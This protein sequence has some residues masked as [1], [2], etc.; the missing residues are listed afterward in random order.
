MGYSTMIYAVDLGK[1]KTAVGSRDTRLVKRLLPGGKKKKKRGMR[2]TREGPWVYLKS[3]G[4]I[5]VNGQIVPYKK[6]I[7]ELRQRKWK[8]KNLYYGEANR[9]QSGP[10]RETQS[11]YE[12]IMDAMPDTQFESYESFKM[13]P[14]GEEVDEISIEEAAAEL[15]EGNV[16]QP[17][18][19][20]QYGYGLE[21]LCKEIGTFL[22][23]IE[24]SGM[25]QAL[26]L[27]TPLSKKRSPIPLKKPPGEFPLI[28]YLTA[29][30]VEREVKRL[31]GMDLSF[32]KDEW[33][34]QD[35]K[36]FLVALRKAAK[37]RLGVVAF[38]H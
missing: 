36:E 20:H 33:I 21:C 18:M 17:E 29:A 8:G 14:G 25:L 2:D 6:V 35:R 28:G 38:Y 15:V 27:N 32:P 26:K 12:A 22:A 10:W 4:E 11:L 23:G 13:S 34:E 7:T 3:N 31:E 9:I 37:K 24:G 5:L 30:E 1:L 19:G 16:S